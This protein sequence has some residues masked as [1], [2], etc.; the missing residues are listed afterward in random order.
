MNFDIFDITNGVS[1]KEGREYAEWSVEAMQEELQAIEETHNAMDEIESAET[2][3][4]ACEAEMNLKSLASMEAQGV[5]D[6]TEIFTRYGLVDDFSMEAAK[7]VL[8]R[9]GYRAIAK[10]K[11][12]VASI[13]KFVQEMITFSGISNKAYAK[14]KK[15]AKQIKEGL[16]KKASSKKVQEDKFVKEITVIDGAKAT[17][18][19]N[20]VK[21]QIEKLNKLDKNIS[22]NKLDELHSLNKILLGEAEGTMKNDDYAEFPVESLEKFKTAMADEYDELK[23]S[24]KESK[25]EFEKNELMV[26]AISNAEYVYTE[27][28]K[29]SKDKTIKTLEKFKKSLSKLTSDRY[30]KQA[31]PQAESKVG[32]ITLTSALNCVQLSSQLVAITLSYDK[33]VNKLIISLYDRMLTECKAVEAMAA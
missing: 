6:A 27:S 19:L 16:R 7:D 17:E 11:T 2:F 12:L 24:F 33:K 31:F 28:G 8:A 3:Y 13:I 23:E 22:A 20:K 18:D 4:K 1:R 26:K 15:L 30:I 10:I 29:L 9:E 32:E 25:E 14:L 21:N 5:A